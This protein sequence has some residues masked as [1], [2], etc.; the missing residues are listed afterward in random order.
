MNHIVSFSS[1]LSSAITAVRVLD[2]HPD[3]LLV[4]MDTNF[5]DED[6]YRF[7]SDFENRFGVKIMR[8]ADGR[9]PYEV[10][11]AQH[12]IPHTAFARRI[13]D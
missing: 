4:F 11:R 9:T 10:S 13:V 2:K 8:L 12:V 5:E 1:G 3:A 6:N 7:M